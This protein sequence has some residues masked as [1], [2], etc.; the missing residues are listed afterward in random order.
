MQDGG[1]KKTGND[2]GLPGLSG[3]QH[4]YLLQLARDAVVRTVQREPH[5]I[6]E[7]T[8]NALAANY[9]AFVTLKIRG[10]LRGC[11]GS[12]VSAKP[13]PETIADM[14][15]KSAT[16]DPRF[17]PIGP[18][19]INELEFDISILGPL[20]EVKEISEIKIGLHGL[21]I[22]QGY[23]RGLLLP[24]VA[25]ENKMDVETFLGHTCM[26]AGLPDDAWRKGAT[27]LKFAAEVF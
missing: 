8:D 22:E 19:E 5:L 12:I 25:T 15:V 3:V 18:S 11:I 2:D 9:G 17:P 6:P 23:K 26:K 10:E 16:T 27:I 1:I 14:A 24:Q 7:Y 4:E 13:I 21:V 20:S